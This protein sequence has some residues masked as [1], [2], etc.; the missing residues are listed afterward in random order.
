MLQKAEGRGQR[1]EEEGRSEVNRFFMNDFGLLCILR[2][3]I[4]NF[5]FSGKQAIA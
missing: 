5:Y 1:A 2:I 4:D 3:Y